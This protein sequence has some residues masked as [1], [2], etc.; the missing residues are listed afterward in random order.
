MRS[1]RKTPHL[2]RV[3]EPTAH[4]V[5]MQDQENAVPDTIEQQRSRHAPAN[6]LPAISSYMSWIFIAS[7]VWEILW[8][9]LRPVWVSGSA[10]QIALFTIQAINADLLIAL[11]T[12]F[13]ALV[14][15][16]SNRWPEEGFGRVC[17]VTIVGA[18][19]FSTMGLW[20]F[21]D[22]PETMSE[23]IAI[24]P[25]ENLYSAM[26]V[27]LKWIILPA[28]AFWQASHTTHNASSFH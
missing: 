25:E 18:W 23:G 8:L 20:L 24:W 11:G 13:A 5:Y 6:W 16:G 3:A 14:I 26:A 1:K 2:T 27:H 7:I 19:G 15:L 10:D 9:P 12:L 22:G 4:T 21:A 28:A 17:L